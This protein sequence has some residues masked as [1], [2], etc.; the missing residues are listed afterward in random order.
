MQLRR[1]SRSTWL[2]LLR[3]AV[4]AL[5]AAG[6]ATAGCGRLKRAAY[7]PG[8][9]DEWQM[10]DRVI[11]AL[12]I[13]PGSRVADIGAGGGYFTFRLARA[14]GPDGVVYAVDVDEEMLDYIAGRA[15]EEGLTNVETRTAQAGDPNL[16]DGEIDLVFTSNTYHHLPDRTAYFAQLRRDLAPDGRVAIVEFVETGW[17]SRWFGH[18]TNPEIIRDELSAAG[19]ELVVDHDFLPRQSFA[20]FAPRAAD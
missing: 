19:Y 18:N 6:V 16:P 9:R 14:V 17:L 13:A 1:P 5:L 7:A 10:P 4:V 2:A 15:A 3:L 20:V 12:A 11:E 8:D